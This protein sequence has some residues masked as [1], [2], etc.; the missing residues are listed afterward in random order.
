MSKWNPSQHPRQPAGIKTGGQFKGVTVRLVKPNSPLV[1]RVNGKVIEKG[2]P[3]SGH[4]GHAGR[5][6]KVGGSAPGDRENYLSEI[7]EAVSA[8]PQHHQDKLSDVKIEVV[9]KINTDGKIE[10][11]GVWNSRTNVIQILESEY[12]KATL[13]HEIGHAILDKAGLFGRTGWRDHWI[14]SHSEMTLSGQSD[15]HEA[16]AD[17]YSWY[18]NPTYREMLGPKTRIYMDDVFQGRGD[19]S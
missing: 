1:I 15:F 13:Y 8:L 6:G 10:P 2:G 17:A 12:S 5:P 11:W 7:N 14:G 18:M 16:F 19:W 3:G 9:S 4:H